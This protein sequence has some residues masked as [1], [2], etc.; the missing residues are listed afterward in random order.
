MAEKPQKRNT[1]ERRK[2]LLEGG[3]LKKERK[4]MKDSD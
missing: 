3:Q 4:Y 2:R 1:E